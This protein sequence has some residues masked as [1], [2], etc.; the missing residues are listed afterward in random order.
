M[1]YLDLR[2]NTNYAFI[3]NLDG[4]LVDTSRHHFKA[5]KQ[6]AEKFD[7]EFTEVLNQQLNGLCCLEA[8]DLILDA[9]QIKLSVDEKTNFAQIKNEIYTASLSTLSEADLFPGVLDF[10]IEGK[11]IETPMAIVTSSKTAQLILSKTGILSF[12]SVVIDSH[13][14]SQS[15]PDPEIYLAASKKLN[16]APKYCIVF[17]NSAKGIEE[18]ISAQMKVVGLGSREK[19]QEADLVFRGFEY[20][21]AYEIINWFSIM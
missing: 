4:V 15:K 6:L 2:M 14:V 7:F 13:M 3:F 8:L 11:R 21:K 5:W 18:G 17:V 1:D 19:L 20:F 10:L 16:Q 9:A 12:F